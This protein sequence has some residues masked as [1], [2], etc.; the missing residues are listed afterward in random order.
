MAEMYVSFY[1]FLTDCKD[2]KLFETDK[3]QVKKPT[4]VRFQYKMAKKIKDELPK[5]KITRDSLAK[6]LRLFKYIGE[7]KWKFFLGMIFLVLTGATA[8]VF[9]RLM[10]LLVDSSQMSLQRINEMG[11][12]LLLLFFAQAVFSFFRVVLFVE[13]TENM[14][15]NVRQ[16]T[17][18]QL[19]K[20]PMAFFAQR[21][22]GEINSRMSS[23]LNQIGDTFTTNIAEFIRQTIIIVG[24]IIA[25]FFTSLKLAFLML[26]VVPV[27]AVIAVLFGRYI[28][29][30]SKTVQDNIAE[31]NT[32]VEETMQGIANVKAFANEL[33]EIKRYTKSTIAIKQMAIKG[34]KARGAFFSFIIFCLFG[35]IILLIWFAVKLENKGELSHGEMMQFMLYTV[36]VGASI[37]GIAEQ[38]A[39]IQRAIGATDRLMDILDEKTEDID[40][41]SETNQPKTKIEGSVSFKNVAFSYPSRKEVQVL[42]NISF[43]VENGRTVAIV[44]PSGSGKSTMAALILRFYDLDS[45]QLLIDGKDSKEYS[46]T[47]LRN[48]MAIVPQDVL[49][50]GGSIK[51][52]IAYGKPD[53]TTEEII[54]AAKKANALDF[55]EGFPE[56]FE[57]IVGERGIKLSGGQRQRVAIARAVLKN[58]SILI[59][60]E[61]TSSLDSESERLV[62][63]ALD[64][65][66]VGRTSFV[67]AHRLS[68]IRQADKII[69]I[70]KGVVKE[71]GTHEELMKSEQ[72]LYKSLSTLQ[73]AN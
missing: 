51:E 32:I 43:D 26:A 24:G 52:N 17:Y 45:G 34:G 8:I 65:L 12:W 68:T 59:L 50:F 4:F 33:F 63:E 3:L 66:M 57:T 21:R 13:V 15:A 53:A 7:Y 40:T 69:V 56:K 39:Q 62:Q 60:D 14:L 25:L 1:C 49:L 38:Y 35:A 16:N 64:K 28:R 27:V 54:D 9:P 47:E 70:D 29:K 5:A 72:G 42:K 18:S 2:R 61:A 30:L 73:F 44:G 22:V 46:L 58:P 31:S 11:L 37:G 71:M 23:D 48:N 10:G 41:V 20:M 19:I 55:I 6:A 36:F 67:I